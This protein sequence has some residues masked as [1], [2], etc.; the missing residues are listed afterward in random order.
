MEF[1]RRALKWV[2]IGMAI[3]IV[4]ALVSVFFLGGV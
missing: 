2:A 3:L 1:D 4:W